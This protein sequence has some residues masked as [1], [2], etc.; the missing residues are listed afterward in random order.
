MKMVVPPCT[1]GSADLIRASLNNHGIQNIEHR[2]R[3][4]NYK[5]YLIILGEALIQSVLDASEGEIQD[6]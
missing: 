2:I 6:K 5:H 1:A 4:I 3:N